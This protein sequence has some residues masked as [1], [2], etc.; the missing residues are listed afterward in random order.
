MPKKV[1]QRTGPE[2]DQMKLPGELFEYSLL[3]R[4][5]HLDTFGHVNNAKYLEILEEARWE[6]ITQNGFGLKDVAKKGMGPVILEVRL[7]FDKELKLRQRVRITTQCIGYNRKV[8]EFEQQILN[9]NNEICACAIFAF[10]LFDTRERKLIEPTPEWLH[11]IGV[12]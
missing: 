8:G 4:E 7:S 12:S 1:R 2:I 6:L 5:S 3:I 10:G 9:E 11:A